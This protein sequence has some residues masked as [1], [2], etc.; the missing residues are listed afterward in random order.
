VVDGAQ[1]ARSDDEARTIIAAT[2]Q[3]RLVTYE[4]IAA[5]LDTLPLVRRR[6]LIQRTILDAAGG[7]H[8]LAE[9]EFLA[10][11]RRGR[12]PTPVCQSVRTDR[13]GRRRYLDALFEEWA[14]HVEIDGAH[15]MD[16]D[17]WWRD[18]RRQNDLWVRGT[19]VLRFPSWVIRRHPVDVLTQVRAALAAAGWRSGMRRESAPPGAQSRHSSRGR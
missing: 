7:A 19:R 18:M 1:W 10:L 8:A 3:Q 16:V 2:F 11:C 17:Q 9:L 14:V 15:H 5:V 4:D 12:L 6:P 13:S